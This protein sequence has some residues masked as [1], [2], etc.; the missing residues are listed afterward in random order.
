[1]RER[2]NKF[3]KQLK[4]VRKTPSGCEGIADFFSLPDEFFC[5]IHSDFKFSGLQIVFY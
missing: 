4:I 1:M 2:R 5:T 3:E